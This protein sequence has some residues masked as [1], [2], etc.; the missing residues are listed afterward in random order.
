MVYFLE[1]YIDYPKHDEL[2]EDVLAAAK[3]VIG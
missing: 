3:I 2:K 1:Q